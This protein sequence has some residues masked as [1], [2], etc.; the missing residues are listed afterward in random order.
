MWWY[1]NYRNSF[2][3]NSSCSSIL[4]E[5]GCGWALVS[6]GSSK[7]CSWPG[8]DSRAS[9][10]D[11]ILKELFDTG[12]PNTEGYSEG[13]S[14]SSTIQGCVGIAWP[15]W[16][17]SRLV[18]PFPM[19]AI[20][21][22]YS[23]L[24]CLTVLQIF[25]SKVL[26]DWLLSLNSCFNNNASCPGCP[27][28]VCRLD[29][30][31]SI[32]FCIP[33]NK[34]STSAR[35]EF[36]VCTLCWSCCL[37]FLFH[38]SMFALVIRARILTLAYPLNSRRCC[39][40]GCVELGALGA[41]TCMLGCL[42]ECGCDISIRVF[43]CNSA[44]HLPMQLQSSL[45]S[46]RLAQHSSGCGVLLG[47]QVWAWS[48]AATVLIASTRFWRISIACMHAAQRLHLHTRYTVFPKTIICNLSYTLI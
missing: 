6:L 35:R 19:A 42:F 7:L 20:I 10:S 31:E 16:S 34:S 15:V 40:E 14:D 9:F 12:K 1:N 48:H 17:T 23:S 5:A 24:T 30:T 43:H 22:F 2:L 18:L 3:Q 41:V 32:S 27:W 47:P 45:F 38:W 13:S 36:N 28:W 46:T 33:V 4:D 21:V 8:F 37:R 25:V 26:A 39:P 44:S 29:V 11:K